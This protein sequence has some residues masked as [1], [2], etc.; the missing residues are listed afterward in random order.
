VEVRCEKTGLQ[1][2]KQ[3]GMKIV[4]G[5]PQSFLPVKTLRLLRKSWACCRRSAAARG[6]YRLFRR[7][8]CGVWFKVSS[9]RLKI[10]WGSASKE[11]SRD[12]WRS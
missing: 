4:C 5:G 8:S 6:A 7:D 11:N 12:R 3:A 2:G 10:P 1:A 9:P